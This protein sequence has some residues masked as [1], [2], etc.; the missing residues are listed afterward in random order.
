[1]IIGRYVSRLSETRCLRYAWTRF[2]IIIS[3]RVFGSRGRKVFLRD[4]F[5]VGASQWTTD[6][7]E[8]PDAGCCRLFSVLLFLSKQIRSRI[9]LVE[10]DPPRELT[11]YLES[12]RILFDGNGH[13]RFPAHLP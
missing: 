2:S 10:K 12:L 13:L 5:F 3:L 7:L 9:V 4:L 1:V 6:R 8:S 11:R